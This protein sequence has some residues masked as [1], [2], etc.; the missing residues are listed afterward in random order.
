MF[1]TN[2]NNFT[3]KNVFL[4]NDQGRTKPQTGLCW[5][6]IETVRFSV[7]SHAMHNY[8]LCVYH[9][10]FHNL[11]QIEDNRN[12]PCSGFVYNGSSVHKD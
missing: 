7:L 2:W 4:L 6:C 8:Y 3:V 5:V 11:S 12:F 1:F 9:I 10:V